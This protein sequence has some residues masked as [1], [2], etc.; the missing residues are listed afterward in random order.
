MSNPTFPPGKWCVTSESTTSRSQ[1]QSDIIRVSIAPTVEN[2]SLET[3][4]WSLPQN[5]RRFV[6]ENRKDIGNRRDAFQ[7]NSRKKESI[8]FGR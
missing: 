7:I 6:H 8:G 4:A 5:F 2:I 1:N 3:T